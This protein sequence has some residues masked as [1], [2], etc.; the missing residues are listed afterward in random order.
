[1]AAAPDPEHGV[2]SLLPGPGARLAPLTYPSGSQR[3]TLSPTLEMTLYHSVT[4]SQPREQREAAAFTRPTPARHQFP[5]MRCTL[6]RSHAQHAHSRPP[7]PFSVL[8]CHKEHLPF[9]RQTEEPSALAFE[10]IGPQTAPQQWPP[11]P[12]SPAG[13]RLTCCNIQFHHCH[14]D[15]FHSSQSSSL[16]SARV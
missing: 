2:A 4:P 10:L 6:Q 8:N 14:N 9:A 1:M 3:R 11:A 15:S 7:T 5:G 12:L 16:I 13:L